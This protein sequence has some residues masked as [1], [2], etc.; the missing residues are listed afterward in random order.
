MS[1]SFP[2]LAAERYFNPKALE[3]TSDPETKSIDLSRFS[4]A[5]QQLPGIYTVAVQVNAT[6]L[7]NQELAFVVDEDGKLIPALTLAQLKQFGLNAEAVP[8]LAALPDTSVITDISTVIPDAACH[9]DFKKLSLAIDIPQAVLR[10]RAGDYIDPAQWN[11]GLPA[12]FTSYNVSGSQTHSRDVSSNDNSA[13]LNL[14]SGANLGEWRLRNYSTW[15]KS[16]DEGDHWDTVSSYLQRDI[17]P[18]KSKLSAGDKFTSSN[19]F[20]SVP[21]RGM[22]LGSDQN[23][24]TDREKEFAPVIRGIARSANARVTV[25]QNSTT[26]YEAYVP[27]GAFVIS[28]L[29]AINS[30]GSLE[31]T[32]TESDGSQ[33]TFTQSYGSVPLMQREGQIAYEVAM[34]EYRESQADSETPRFGQATALYGL[35]RDMT[36]YA[37]AIAGQGYDAFLMGYGLNLGSVGSFSLDITQSVTDIEGESFRGQKYRLQYAKSLAVTG[38]NVSATLEAFPGRHYF[39]LQDSV[40]YY[41]QPDESESEFDNKRKRAEIALNQPIGSVGSLSFSGNRQIYWNKQ[42]ETNL[43]ASW[44]STFSKVNYNVSYT[45]SLGGNNDD[46]LFLFSLQVP[47][48]AFLSGA[49]SNYSLTTGKSRSTAQTAGISGTALDDNRLNYNVSSSFGESANGGSVNLSYKAKGGEASGGYSDMDGSRR[50]SYGTQGGIVM[51]PYGITFSQAFNND[52]TLALVKL[53]QAPDVEIINGTA[54]ATD[55]RGYAIVPNIQPYRRNTVSLEPSSFSPNMEVGRSAVK[56]IPNQGALVLANFDVRIGERVLITLMRNG[57]PVPFGSQASVS[58][59]SSSG[60]VAENGLVYLA[61]MPASGVI[62]VNWGD[63]PDEQCEAPYLLPENTG[64]TS[65]T[66]REIHVD[67]L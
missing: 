36:V 52:A 9:F 16:S 5:G 44:N 37:G 29:Y 41:R 24:L 18:L 55:W 23:M 43:S 61:G 21:L 67:C 22:V 1:G 20:D 46:A 42:S 49:W 59:V 60:I 13:Y 2:V 15:R 10:Q 62:S 66:L 31:V 12:L 51:H 19:I 33:S 11:S 39:S 38:T 53:P 56:M 50:V 57:I 25:K 58:Q 7:E 3:L 14:N 34:G 35:P 63:D 17:R 40:D 26:I 8:S 27:A 65:R 30:S 45:R 47:L 28:D 48:E 64:D 54:L 32:V 6:R 4:D